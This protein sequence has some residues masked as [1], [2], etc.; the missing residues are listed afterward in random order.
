MS[1]P[2]ILVI[3]VLGVG[4]ILGLL[5]WFFFPQSADA[6]GEKGPAGEEPSEGER[7]HI[8]DEGAYHKTEAYYPSS[9]SL[10]K[11]SGEEEAKEAAFLLESFVKQEVARFKDSVV[12]S[13]TEEDI[14]VQGLGKERQYALTVDYSTHESTATLSYVYHMY[15]D[16]LGAHP[17]VYYRTFVFDKKT[18]EGLHLDDLFVS[19]QYLDM[20]SEKTR[21]SLEETLGKDASPD[22][23]EAGT[24]PFPDNFQNFYLDNDE[25]V[26]IFPPYQVGPWAL[27]TLEARIPRSELSPFFKIEY[28]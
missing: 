16:T 24:T 28:R 25:L 21:A 4:A 11:T 15:A 10:A 22:M 13:L 14:R 6:P 23:L 3:I 7:I 20:L 18:G 9:T 26:I 5:F 27:G 1:R 19:N 17:N 8:R 2:L 12:G